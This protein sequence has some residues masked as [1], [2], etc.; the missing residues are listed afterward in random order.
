MLAAQAVIDAEAPAF[1]VGEE[2]MDPGQQHVGGRRLSNIGA[3][4]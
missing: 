1:E 4:F 2:A 3:S